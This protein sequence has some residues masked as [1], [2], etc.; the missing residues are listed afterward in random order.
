MSEHYYPDP[1]LP[2]NTL[3]VVSLILGIISFS[4]LPLIGAV[5][6]VVTGHVARQQIKARP[7]TFGGEGFATA[8]LILGY[9]HLALVFIS[10]VLIIIA[11]IMAPS[12][13]D[14]ITRLLNSIR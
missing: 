14:W 9:A 6:A 1:P 10:L 4:I 3:A 7:Y 8:G 11:L 2:V 12:V 13:V 5:A